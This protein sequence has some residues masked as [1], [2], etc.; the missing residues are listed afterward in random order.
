MHILHGQWDNG[1][2]QGQR[3][4]EG[5][6][7]ELKDESDRQRDVGRVDRDRFYF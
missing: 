6:I 2:S 4:E 3:K 1:E 5:G 7:E